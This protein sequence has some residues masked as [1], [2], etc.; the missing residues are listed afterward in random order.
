MNHEFLESAEFYNRRYHN[1]SSRVII[2]TAVL[3][4]F[5]LLFALFAT[6]EITVAARATIEP[7]RIIANIQS[8]SNNAIITNNLAENKAVK[9]GDLLIQYQGGAETVQEA[10]YSRQLELLQDQKQQLEYLQASLETG[11][12]QFP[13]AD[14]FGYQQSFRDY[15]S[16]A[17]S[18][19][20]NSD[21]QNATIASQNAASANSQAELGNLISETQAKI[22]DYQT[23][24]SAI[25]NGTSLDSTNAGYSLYQAYQAQAETDSTGALKSQTVA[26]VDAQISQ[27]ESTLAGYRVQY[28]GSGAQQAYSESLTSQLESLKSQQLTRVGQELT[29]LKQKI[30]DAETGK[31]VQGGLVQKGS[32][33]AS[34]DGILHL[35]AETSHSTLVPEGTLLAQLYPVLTTE[36]KV[37][38]TAYIPSKDMAQI[39]V[40]DRIR[41]TTVSDLNKQQ[42][43]TSTISTI[44]STATKLEQGNFFKLEAET[45]LTDQEASQLRYGLE[46]RV[47]M[48]TGKKTYFQYYLDQFLK[49]E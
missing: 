28:A 44:D 14:N 30:L 40:G 8:T 34:E 15:L 35:N 16:Q 24:K 19:R 1:F 48:M 23:A 39:K 31:E 41:F 27:L 10:N 33:T 43:L 9:Q 17:D 45:Q 20:A 3:L 37:K 12:D 32:I 29:S 38:I 46:G 2:P 47:V 6:K 7:N 5:V 42:N 11:S 22:A 21:Q 13:A 25:Q 18:L 49:R 26:Q 4:V 36:K